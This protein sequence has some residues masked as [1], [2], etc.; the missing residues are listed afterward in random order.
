MFLNAVATTSVETVKELLKI[1]HLKFIN[2]PGKDF[3]ISIYQTT[4][5]DWLDVMGDALIPSA[6]SNPSYFQGNKLPVESVSWNAVQVFIKKLNDKNDGH[7]YR[8][9]TGAEWEYCCRAGSTTDYYFG[10]DYETLKEYAWYCENSDAKTHE[11]GLLKPNLFGLYDMHGNVWEWCQNLHSPERKDRV[12]RGGSF[13][14]FARSA[15]SAS[16]G[17]VH[18]SIPEVH[19]GFRLV[20]TPRSPYAL[21]KNIKNRP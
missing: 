21:K 3:A 12:I 4:Q 5:K 10:S 20:R 8:L 15:C 16:S 11:V 7:T 9:P 18:P 1:Q 19:V 6:V 17:T 13:C 2:I 14:D